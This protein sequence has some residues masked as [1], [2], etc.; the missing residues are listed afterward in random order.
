[1]DDIGTTTDPDVGIWILILLVF[2]AI[3]FALGYLFRTWLLTREQVG[4]RNLE[5]ENA[6]LKD[7]LSDAWD[8]RVQPVVVEPMEEENAPEDLQTIEGIGPKIAFLLSTKSIDS[9]KKLAV[10]DVGYLKD[11]LEEAGGTFGTHDP[12]TWPYQARLATEG[13]WQ[14]LNEYQS[15][16]HGGRQY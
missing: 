12:T 11:I 1:M 2:A 6:R 7:E 9:L 13:K 5:S 8:A 4:A 15:L 3:M 16:L 10:S 14:E